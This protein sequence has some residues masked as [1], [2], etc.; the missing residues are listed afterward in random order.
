MIKGLD[1]KIMYQINEQNRKSLMNKQLQ[2]NFILSE[3]EPSKLKLIDAMEHDKDNFNKKVKNSKISKETNEEELKEKDKK[4]EKMKTKSNLKD[5]LNFDNDIFS[6]DFYKTWLNEI[7]GGP[8][9]LP[10][11]LE[12]QIGLP[13]PI[14]K[15]IKKIKKIKKFH[16]RKHNKK[17]K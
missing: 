3:A 15:S 2:K 14:K 7:E 4:L 1:R 10:M 8:E 17:N 9:E 12:D 13:T 6:G 11:K 16:S 5:I